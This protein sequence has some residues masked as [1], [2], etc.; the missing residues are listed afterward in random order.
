MVIREYLNEYFELLKLQGHPLPQLLPI[1]L[2]KAEINE[3]LC[4]LEVEI[5]EIIYELFEW[6]KGLNY[7]DEKPPYMSRNLW[8]LGNF[9]SLDDCIADHK[10]GVIH[11]KLDKNYFPIFSN[12][13]GDI[14]YINFLEGNESK[15]YIYSPPLTHS[16]DLV[17]IYD[18][19]EIMLVSFIKALK[20][21]IFSYKGSWI[22]DADR[23]ARFFKK[24]NP[25]SVYWED[26]ALDE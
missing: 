3:K 25:E 12:P 8:P 7:S 26:K 24:L 2:S 20:E 10:A 22:M 4:F 21:G 5:P 11:D 16:M 23:Y 6:R 9:Y 1:G 19:M 15:V 17:S 14:W 13:G 18:S